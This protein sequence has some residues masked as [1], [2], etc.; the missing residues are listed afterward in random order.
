MSEVKRF[1]AG[2]LSSHEYV[3]KAADFDRLTAERDSAL[4]EL[5]QANKKIDQAWNRTSALDHKGFI[6]GALDA[7]K[8]PVPQHL[9]YDFSG[10]P[11]ASATQYCNGWNDCGGYWSAHASE[12]QQR[13]KAL[14]ALLTAADERADV[15][16]RALLEVVAACDLAMSAIDDDERGENFV[17]IISAIKA[18]AALKSVEGGGDEA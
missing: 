5:A 2:E 14:Q 15:Q 12:L 3:I 4:A 7:W 9:P 17:Q 11:G 13:E 18:K 10:N 8:R 6:P 16:A 1:Y